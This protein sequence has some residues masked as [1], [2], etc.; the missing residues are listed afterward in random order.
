MCVLWLWET[1]ITWFYEDKII[2]NTQYT[3]HIPMLR[4]IAFV[5]FTCSPIPKHMETA[6]KQSS[7]RY[8]YDKY[9][10]RWMVALVNILFAYLL[11]NFNINHFPAQSLLQSALYNL[12]STQHNIYNIMPTQ[13]NCYCLWNFICVYI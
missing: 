5:M 2:W 9:L 10:T 12:H 3:N 11:L 13:L 7:C 1:Y 8:S 4:F 6:S